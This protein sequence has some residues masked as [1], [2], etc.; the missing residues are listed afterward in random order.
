MRFSIA[1]I[2]LAA[3]YLV[4]AAPFK[5]AEAGDLTVLSE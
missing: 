5:R 2:A 3:P 4:S 1:L